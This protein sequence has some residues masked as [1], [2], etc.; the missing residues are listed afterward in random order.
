ML[1]GRPT[2]SKGFVSERLRGGGGAYED[3]EGGLEFESVIVDS[4]SMV[5]VVCGAWR[6][7][8]LEDG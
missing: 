6:L 2:Y 8:L 1:L 7:C 5:T 4:E 3:D